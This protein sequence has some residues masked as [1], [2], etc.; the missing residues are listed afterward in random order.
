MYTFGREKKDV[1][2]TAIW[3]VFAIFDYGRSA[4]FGPEVAGVETAI[5]N[6]VVEIALIVTGLKM[7][8]PVELRLFVLK[9]WV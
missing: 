7:Q 6:S 4:V 5:D 2:V 9:N 8:R 1:S 3:V